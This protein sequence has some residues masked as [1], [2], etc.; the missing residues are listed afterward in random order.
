VEVLV[1]IPTGTKPF[2]RNDSAEFKLD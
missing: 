1:Y 2:F